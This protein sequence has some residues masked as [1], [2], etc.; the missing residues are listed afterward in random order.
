MSL[1]DI[2]IKKSENPKI[3]EYLTKKNQEKIG[4]FVGFKINE[5]KADFIK[6]YIVTKHLYNY[7]LSITT[8]GDYKEGEKKGKLLLKSISE[9]YKNK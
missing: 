9:Y 8:I 3:E 6:N 4:I 5:I 2:G 7:P 1:D